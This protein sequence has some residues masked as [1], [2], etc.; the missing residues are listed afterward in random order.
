MILSIFVIS[1]DG[2]KCILFFV[3]R[4]FLKLCSVVLFG[5][6]CFRDDRR[7]RIS[8]LIFFIYSFSFLKICIDCKWWDLV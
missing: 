3:Y 8:F 2:D 5:F 1:L 6:L 4:F 7:E